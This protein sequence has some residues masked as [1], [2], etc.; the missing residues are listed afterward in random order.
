MAQSTSRKR[1]DMD[2]VR[3][4]VFKIEGIMRLKHG[5]QKFSIEKRGIRKD[6]V[7]E[8]VL[9]ELGSR[10]KLPRFHIKITA[11]R[12]IKEDEITDPYVAKIGTMEKVMV[13]KTRKRKYMSL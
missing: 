9:S 10:H 5:W 13:Y 7:V 3:V 6:E 4:R 8:R 12:E 11:I 2:E 1:K